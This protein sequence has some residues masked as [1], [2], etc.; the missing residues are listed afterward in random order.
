[1]QR[2]RKLAQIVVLKLPQYF[3]QHARKLAHAQMIDSDSQLELISPDLSTTMPRT[4]KRRALTGYRRLM[5]APCCRPPPSCRV[6][7]S[8]A[9]VLVISVVGQRGQRHRHIHRRR[10]GG[11]G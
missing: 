8:L 7:S 11:G 2:A 5:L 3:L 10:A 1:L 4:P 9:L 6:A